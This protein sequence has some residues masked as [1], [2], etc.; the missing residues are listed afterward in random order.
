M[1]NDTMDGVVYSAEKRPE[2]IVSE[3]IR[4]FNAEYNCR[5]FNLSSGNSDRV[6]G[7]GRQM[8]WASMLDEL[9]KELD[10][11][12]IVSAGNV[13]SPNV[14]TFSGRKDL[15]EQTRNQLLGDEHRL[16]DPATTA[17]G[18][19][20]GSITRYGEP[21]NLSNLTT[22][23]LSSGKAGYPSAFTRA[24]SG[25]NGAIKPDFVDYGGNF[26]IRQWAPDDFRW[27][28]N[29]ALNEPTL[30]NT[31]D[32]VFKGWSGTSFAAPH[33]THIA[34]R[35][36]RA[37]NSQ[38]GEEPSANLIR[39]LL[40]SSAKYAEKEWLEA[41]T[42]VGFSGKTRR[43]QEWRL[44]LSGYGKVDD[45]TLFTDRNHV[46]LFTE[47]AL[48][49]RQIHLYKIPVPTEFLK[50]NATKRIAVGFAYNPPTRL[51][52]KDY[53]ANSLW[54]EV[55]RRIDIETLLNY[56]GKKEKAEEE[57]A[58]QIMDNFAQ[59]YGAKDFLPGYTEVRNSTLQQR[60]WEKPARGGSD[61]LWKENDPY[62]YILV[63][64]KA[65]FKHPSNMEAQPYALAITFS[66][67]GE[68]DIQLRQRLSDRVNIKQREQIRT[69]TQVQV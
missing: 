57:A 18:V 66:Y 8:A 24:G 14:P 59:Q 6:Y 7:G 52:R 34:A 67:D 64:G 12:I 20:V 47:E 44:R 63:T 31:N 39:A 11:V 29:R 56:K 15:M 32:N 21:D 1:H 37:L 17:L 40:A 69:R 54:F 3:A 16:I 58:E 61:L 9:S 10:I 22:V 43:T 13:A 2:Q 23:L 19:T 42:P 50:L 28:V 65:K 30:S 46:T 25:V 35:L 27:G 60:V 51:S 41:V 45:T 38:L 62:I 5:I 4:Y 33:V 49:L 48:Y 36:Q 55:F 68:A 26:A 53:I